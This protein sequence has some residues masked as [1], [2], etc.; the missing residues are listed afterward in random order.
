MTILVFPQRPRPLKSNTCPYCGAP[1][2]LYVGCVAQCQAMT[3][4]HRLVSDA[5]EGDPGELEERDVLRGE[6]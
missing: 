5:A 2:R 6:D 3:A 1:Y 4:H